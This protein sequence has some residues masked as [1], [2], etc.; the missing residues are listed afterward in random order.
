MNNLDKLQSNTSLKFKD[1]HNLWQALVH[2]SF[3][4]ENKDQKMESN[5]RLEFLG[6]AILELWISDTLFKKFPEFKEGDLTNLRSLIVCTTNLAKVA[7]KINLGEFIFLSK[8][9]ETHGGRE[10]QSILADTFEA[11]IGSIFLDQ[12]LAAVS[13]FLSKFLNPSIEYYSSQKIYKDPKSIFQEIAQAEKGIT[14]HYQTLKES[15]PDHKKI[16]KVGLYLNEELVTTGQGP[17][18][19][20][21]EEDASV[22]ATKIFTNLV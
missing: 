21:A 12:N 2:R 19:Q 10:N 20:R 22:K 1:E 18:K 8:G 14:P 7:Q 4:N 17:S 11:L 3:L 16:F 9:E 13:K 5:E 15:G 6:D